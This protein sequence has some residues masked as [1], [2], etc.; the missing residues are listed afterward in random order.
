MYTKS[1]SNRCFMNHGFSAG[2]DPGRGLRGPK[3]PLGP[4]KKFLASKIFKKK[5]LGPWVFSLAPLEFLARAPL[6]KIMNP[7][8]SSG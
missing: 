3:P 1:T 2:T 8:P 4:K 5:G 6:P 7:S